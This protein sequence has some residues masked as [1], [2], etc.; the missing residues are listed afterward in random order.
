MTL[1]DRRPDV[2]LTV[3]SANKLVLKK[4]KEEEEFLSYY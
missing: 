4:K 1:M 3:R 2:V